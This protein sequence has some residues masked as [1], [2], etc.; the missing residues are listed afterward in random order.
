MNEETFEWP[1]AVGPAGQ[2]PQG[3]QPWEYQPQPTSGPQP[4]AV[5]QPAPA[6]GVAP[7]PPAAAQPQYQYVGEH[8]QVARRGIPIIQNG[9]SLI[10]GGNVT[11]LDGKKRLV[12]EAPLSDVTVKVTKLK[13][14]K[15]TIGNTTYAIA[16]GAALGKAMSGDGDALKTIVR[17]FS[18]RKAD[19]RAIM[20]CTQ[21]ATAQFVEIFHQLK[22][23]AHPTPS[24]S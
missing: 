13:S 21:A 12:A 4:Q 14:T 1:A 10:G 2:P 9:T 16:V 22:A 19:M 18:L 7:Q 23:A 15:L 20:E 11:L 8:V 24:G 5:A 6:W 17:G 3:A